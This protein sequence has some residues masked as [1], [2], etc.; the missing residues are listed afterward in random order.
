M[1]GDG[2]R[3]ELIVVLVRHQHAGMDGLGTLRKLKEQRAACRSG[4]GLWRRNER[5]RK[6][7]SSAPPNSSPRP[8]RFRPAEAAA[9]AA[10]PPS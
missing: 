2:I 5:R 1:L 10:A 3:P 7:P 9:A 8:V 6:P 4:D